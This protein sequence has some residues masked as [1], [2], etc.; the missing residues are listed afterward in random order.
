MMN[1]FAAGQQ[2]LSGEFVLPSGERALVYVRV[3]CLGGRVGAEDV[4]AVG[5]VRKSPQSDMWAHKKPLLR[6]CVCCFSLLTPH[7]RQTNNLL[8]LNIKHRYC[9]AVW[10]DDQAAEAQPDDE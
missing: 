3:C 7:Y 10:V 4:C 2:L 5:R 1:E 6:V 9:A 8:M